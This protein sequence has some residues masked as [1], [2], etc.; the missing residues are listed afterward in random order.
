MF[1]VLVLCYPNKVKIDLT[2]VYLNAL[3][4]TAS[5]A[6]STILLW[7]FWTNLK[8]SGLVGHQWCLISTFLKICPSHKSLSPPN[9][10]TAIHLSSKSS[11][12]K[13]IQSSWQPQQEQEKHP[14]LPKFSEKA[15]MPIWCSPLLLRHP[16]LLLKFSFNQSFKLKESLETSL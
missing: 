7:L 14:L 11:L 8:D 12:K 10:L 1:G 9:K 4:L 6:P 15:L 16:L 2:K 3:P 5:K 13:K